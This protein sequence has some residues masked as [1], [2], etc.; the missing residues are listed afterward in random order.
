MFIILKEPAGPYSAYIDPG[1]MSVEI[2]EAWN[3]VIFRTEDGEAL[4]VMMR[5]NGYELNYFKQDEFHKNIK[6]NEGNINSDP[7]RG[8]E[9]SRE[10]GQTD[11]N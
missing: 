10:I 6:L 9:P 1:V 2:T 5:D 4:S 7:P 11:S 3:G 8:L